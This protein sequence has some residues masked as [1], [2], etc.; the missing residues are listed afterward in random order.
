MQALVD[1]LPAAEHAGGWG[2]AADEMDMHRAA[3]GRVAQAGGPGGGARDNAQAPVVSADVQ[4][5]NVA[6]LS[7]T[8]S[9]AFI[10]RTRS[11]GARRY[12]A[13]GSGRISGGCWA[14]GRRDGGGAPV[15]RATQASVR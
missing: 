14:W 7:Y 9:S 12:A 10:F 4:V 8:T 15:V 6:G 2:S 1:T 11:E 3:V 13:T 5:H